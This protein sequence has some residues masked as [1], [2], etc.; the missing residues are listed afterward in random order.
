[1]RKVRRLHFI[2]EKTA[3][4]HQDQEGGLTPGVGGRM[5]QTTGKRISVTDQDWYG[6]AQRLWLSQRDQDFI[7]EVRERQEGQRRVAKELDHL[8]VYGFRTGEH[9]QE[10]STKKWGRGARKSDGT[11]C[12]DGKKESEVKEKK[13]LE[14]REKIL[15]KKSRPKR[16]THAHYIIPLEAWE[17]E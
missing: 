17:G 4:L 1:L 9:R 11:S 8:A 10:L 2:P 14:G 5:Y 6:G 3:I 16:G 15:S 12:N 7:I 13:V